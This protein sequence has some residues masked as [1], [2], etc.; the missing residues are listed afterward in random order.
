MKKICAISF[1]C[2]VAAG[3]QTTAKD[4]TETSSS[5]IEDSA[6]A[7]EGLPIKEVLEEDFCYDDIYAS[8]LQKQFIK[9]KSKEISKIQARK[10]RITR[11]KAVENDSLFFARNALVGP[12]DPYFGAIPVTSHHRV[13]FWMRYFKTRGRDTFL[14]W[15]VRAESYRDVVTPILK[16]EGLPQ[17]FLYLAMVESGFNDNA[18]SSKSATGAWQFMKGTGLLYDL[19]I[20]Y[21]VDE[22][23]DPA[24]STVAAARYLRDLYGQFGD[25]YLAMAAY[26]AGPGKI[27]RAISKSKSRDFWKISE[28]NN[29]RPETKH[30]VPKVLAALNLAT[31]AKL[32]GFE[33]TQNP[34]DIAPTSSVIL[35]RPIQ[36]QELA[37]MLDIPIRSLQKWNPELIRGITPPSSKKQPFYSIRIPEIT[38]E[39]YNEIKDQLAIVE[40]TDVLMHKVRTGDTLSMLARKYQVNITQI[41]M[42]NPQLK[43]SQLRIGREIAIPIPG[44]VTKKSKKNV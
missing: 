29:I 16:S 30:Y 14:K 33:F 31:N 38:I 42:L 20:N 7:E 6:L 39:K 27:R 32:H 4:S 3:C 13:E 1:L 28:T 26:N 43:E 8:Y 23:R 12:F 18:Y 10:A 5:E 19:K 36:M 24:K 40:I 41:K 11:E 17:E 35:D 2:Y 34:E 9:E 25:W 37:G 21:W 22:R 44:V 15:L